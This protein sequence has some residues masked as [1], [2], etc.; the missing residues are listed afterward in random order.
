MARTTDKADWKHFKAWADREH[1]APRVRA[2]MWNLFKTDPDYYG[3]LGW[4]VVHERV[5]DSG[6]GRVKNPRKRRLARNAKY[7]TPE[8]KAAFAR[9]MKQA[10]ALAARGAKAAGKAA[11]KYGDKAVRAA[12]VGTYHAVKHGGRAAYEQLK[13]PRGSKYDRCLKK[14][15]RSLK[16]SHRSGNEYAICSRVKRRSRA[17]RRNFKDTGRRGGFVRDSY[18]IIAKRGNTTLYY[19]GKHF[20]SRANLK[21]FAYQQAAA[22]QARALLRRYP[23]LTG[24]RVYVARF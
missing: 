8:R 7:W 21:R 10:R 22:T 14:V 17:L 13:N 19:N 5:R 11:L 9:R 16:R 2:A 20:G 12:A 24:Y 6:V 18:G 3:D 1:I 4:R 15:R 23:I